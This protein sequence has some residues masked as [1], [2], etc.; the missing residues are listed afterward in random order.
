M[1]D[2]LIGQIKGSLD[3]ELDG[4]RPRMGIAFGTDLFRE[5][6]E[7]GWITFENLGL[8]HLG[9]SDPIPMY[10][11]THFAICIWDVPETEYRIGR[12]A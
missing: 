9:F 12:D 2:A 5:F 4:V 8:G 3:K 11:K 7:R 10:S 1:D 6:R